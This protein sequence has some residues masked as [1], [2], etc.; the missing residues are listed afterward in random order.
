[1]TNKI[2]WIIIGVLLAFFCC[3]GIVGGYGFY[4]LY[5]AGDISLDSIMDNTDFKKTQPSGQRVEATMQVPAPGTKVDKDALETRNILDTTI[6]PNNDLR[7]LAMRLKGIKDIPETTGLPVEKYQI[8]DS[9]EFNALNTDTNENFKITASLAYAT[10]HAYFW[11]EDGVDYDKDKVKKLAEIF[12]TKIY[13]TDREFFGSEW[14]PGVDGDV[15]LYIIYARGLGKNI[16]G[17]FSSIDSVNPLA[18]PDSNGHESFFMS[19]DNLNFGEE[20]MGTLAHEFQHMIHWYRD[21]NED[22]WMNEGFSVLAEFLNKFDTGGFDELYTMNPDQQLTDW[23]D[24]QDLTTPHYGESFLFLTYFLDRFGENATKQLVAEPENGMPAIDK[25]LKNI[26]A[27]DKLT[28]EQITADDVFA[29]WVVATLL[30]DPKAGDGRYVYSNYPESP[31]PDVTETHSDCPTSILDRTVSQYGVDYIRF[32]CKGDFKLNFQGALE[33]GVLADN[34]HSG[35]YAFWS[36]KGD[37]SDMTLTREF[38][39]ST[40][41]SNI[42]MDYWIW[43]DLETDFDF[44]Y[45]EYSEDGK[46]WKII[47]TVS[48]TSVNKSGN[49]YGCGWNDSSNGWKKESIDLS[50]LAGK[51]VQLRFEYITDAAVNG[52]GMM[53]DDISIPALN[54]QTDFESDN[55]GWEPAGFVRIQNKLPQSYKISLIEYGSPTK[56]T[57]INL[58]ESNQATVPVSITDSKGAVLVVSGTTRTSRQAAHYQFSLTK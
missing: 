55:G 35:K 8:G 1:M 50:F 12:E 58:D 27:V 40:L 16:A 17:L 45:L 24:D 46:E 20:D 30:K 53:L 15:H 47:P 32:K 4:K 7:E 52:E 25:V 11:I 23:P 19:A 54:Y 38:D 34:P 36:N 39:F 42:E 49:N 10:D 57:S 26:N 33:I 51:K 48:C 13:P 5:E 2:I 3:C 29:D 31:Q 41:T 14:T 22:T 18:R 37:E 6:V 28:G 9:K 21:R 44:A 43:Y 56:V